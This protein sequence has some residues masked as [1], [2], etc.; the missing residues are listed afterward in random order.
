MACS[1]WSFVSYIVRLANWKG[2]VATIAAR[3]NLVINRIVFCL[4]DIHSK[5]FAQV[6]ISLKL[7]GIFKKGKHE[8]LLDATP[9]TKVA[10]AICIATKYL[11][12]E[13]RENIGGKMS[14]CSAF[15]AHAQEG[16]SIQE[17]ATPPAA[18]FKGCTR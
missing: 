12:D 3:P 13:R 15:R 8:K 16:S 18:S 14:C 10:V 4:I 17:R 7:F 5:I 9:P 2:K 1:V 11:V 6:V